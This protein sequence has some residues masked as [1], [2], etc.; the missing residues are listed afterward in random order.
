MKEEILRELTKKWLE[1]E[2]ADWE[3]HMD[4]EIFHGKGPLT[5]HLLRKFQGENLVTIPNYNSVNV[6][7]D[8]AGVVVA[9]V[10]R[11]K[12][13]VIA[14]V[15]GEE[16]PLSQADRRQARDYAQE[17]NAFEAYLVSDGPIGRDVA[18]DIRNGAHSFIGMFKNG[19]TGMCYLKF[20]RYVE[21]TGQ[22]IPNRAR[23]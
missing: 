4:F 17:T 12:L 6:E 15:K 1:A 21:R 23:R 3:I 10:T 20:I 7:P 5:K 14:E 22:F 11:R 2:Y 18:K 9:P 19:Q 16:S 13:W 8:V